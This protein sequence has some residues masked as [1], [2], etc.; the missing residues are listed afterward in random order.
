MNHHSSSAEQPNRC[1]LKAGGDALID[2]QDY[3]QRTKEFEIIVQRKKR[4]SNAL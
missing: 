3:K 1:D 4:D 2:R